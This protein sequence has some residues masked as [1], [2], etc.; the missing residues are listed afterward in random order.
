MELDLAGFF[1]YQKI[2]STMWLAFRQI[3][4]IIIKVVKL[5]TLIVK[6]ETFNDIN[7]NQ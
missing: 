5:V 3:I 6:L 4:A 7:D 1:D 2:F